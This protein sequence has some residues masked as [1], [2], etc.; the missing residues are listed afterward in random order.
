MEYRGLVLDRFQEDAIAALREGHC[1]LVAAPTGTG[2]TII[3][4]WIVEDALS[5]GREV[6]YTAPIKAL[7]NQ[8]YRDYVK[9]YGEEKVG[10]V[11]GDLVIRRDAPCRVMTTE[12]LRNMLL[13]GETL[14]HLQ[15]VILDEIHFLDDR[16]R[17]TVWEEV[18]IYLPKP[19]QIVGLSATLSNLQDFAAWLE[20]VRERK[21]V[22]VTETKRA[23]PLEIHYA[24]VDTGIVS[25]AEY[26]RQFKRK[27]HRILAEAGRDARGG[28]GR[29]RGRGGRGG[30]GDRGGRGGRRPARRTHPNDLHDLVVEADLLPYLYFVFSRRDTE[31]CARRLGE[32]AGSLLDADESARLE[33]VLRERAP[34]LGA[35]LDQELRALYMKGIAFHHAGLHVQLKALVE[36]LYEDHLIKALF[37]TSTFALGIN[38][39]A[40]TVVFD[41][42]KMFDGRAFAALT[43][44]QFMQMAGRA[45]RRGMDEVGHV[46]VRLDLGDYQDARPQLQ[47]YAESRV[48]PVRSGFNLSWNSVVNLIETYGPER[49]REIVEKSF[50][51]WWR[52]RTADRLDSSADDKRER[53]MQKRAE[54][55][56]GRCW[57]EFQGKLA[58]L[59]HI[60]YLT[61]DNGFNAGARIL[62]HLQMSEILVCELVLEGMFEDLDPHELFGVLCAL[63]NELARHVKPNFRARQRDRTLATRISRVR[64]APRVVD[65]EELTGEQ[66]PF[67]PV[68]IPIGMAWSKGTPLVE[69]VQMLESQTDIAG[70]LITGFRR[71]KDLAG[72]L[73]DVYAEDE[74]TVAILDAL[75]KRVSRDEVQVVG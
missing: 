47:R 34:A 45:G 46:V 68:L 4:D 60:G 44:R 28:R 14:P 65:A 12:V 69:V 26:D 35:A 51:N 19:V 62:S 33:A 55:D 1:A 38:L 39:P 32:H 52:H 29:G 42:L 49:C 66:Y 58:Y 63:T 9:L 16:D 48:E 40:R 75:V 74:H 18:L 7:S 37:C 15:A 23:V 6:I 25:P 24:C 3:A 43:T 53:R 20:D 30:R 67:D 61:A 5:N 10:L 70:D 27:G 17:G 73:R 50:L 2:K 11:T 21:V 71:A 59:R 54:R 13:S 31:L 72:Q 41:G 56:R 57:E 8:K 36:E 64:H 22:T